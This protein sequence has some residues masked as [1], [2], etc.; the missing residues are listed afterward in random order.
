MAPASGSNAP[1]LTETR[2][3]SSGDPVSGG[4]WAAQDF[5][6][7]LGRGVSEGPLTMYLYYA[8]DPGETLGESEAMR[9]LK[10][11]DEA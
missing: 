4:T 7:R 6:W 2:R 11:L 1:A 8:P 9:M 5:L 3:Q 10:R